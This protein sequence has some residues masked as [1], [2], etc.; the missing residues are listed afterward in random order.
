MDST[1][2]L[3]R[4]QVFLASALELLDEANAPSDIGAHVDR[5]IERLSEALRDAEQNGQYE[6]AQRN[7]SRGRDATH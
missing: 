7:I 4:A 1:N 3:S 2:L 5:A 6:S